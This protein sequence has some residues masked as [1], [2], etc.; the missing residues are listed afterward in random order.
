MTGW[1]ATDERI[2]AG[3]ELQRELFC[4]AARFRSANSPARTVVP[5]RADV[6]DDNCEVAPG[7][8]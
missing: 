4:S 3:E 5:G 1:L 8:P 2:Q 7:S 6:G